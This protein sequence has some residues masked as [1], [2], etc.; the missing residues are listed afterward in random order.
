MPCTPLAAAANQLARKRPH[1]VALKGASSR[2]ALSVGVR[3]SPLF[4]LMNLFIRPTAVCIS[5]P[6]L[7]GE[8]NTARKCQCEPSFRTFLSP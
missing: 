7:L 4:S 6:S 5:V 3:T 8:G 2:I 1:A